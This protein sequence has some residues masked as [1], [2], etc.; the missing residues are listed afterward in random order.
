MTS[1]KSR[2]QAHLIGIIVF[3]AVWVHAPID[4]WSNNVW[5]IFLAAMV[6]SPS[7]FQDC[8]VKNTDIMTSSLDCDVMIEIIIFSAALMH[9]PINL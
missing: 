1:Q 4:L 8:R 9:A 3:S 2:D 6:L 7:G 5:F